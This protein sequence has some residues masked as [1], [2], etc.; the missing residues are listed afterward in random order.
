MNRRLCGMLWELAERFGEWTG[1]EPIH[2]RQVRSSA[3]MTS[4]RGVGGGWVRSWKAQS[5]AR[6]ED[7][8]GRPPRC[9]SD[10]VI[11]VWRDARAQRLR[12]ASGLPAAHSQR[13]SRS[14]SRTSRTAR[15]WTSG[16]HLPRVA[17]TPA[18]Q[19]MQSLGNPGAVLVVKRCLRIRL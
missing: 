16:E 12:Q 19:F 1:V 7:C 11:S 8:C 3:K 9:S 18:A 14:F 5:P 17:I 13:C 15:S 4:E 2:R 6:P 10:V